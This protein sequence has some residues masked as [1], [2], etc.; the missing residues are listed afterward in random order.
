MKEL[1]RTAK[2]SESHATDRLATEI[3]LGGSQRNAPGRDC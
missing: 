3:E 1:E 2:P